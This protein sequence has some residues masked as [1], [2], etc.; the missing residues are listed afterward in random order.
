M[1]NFEGKE[2]CAGGEC[3]PFSLNPRSMLLSLP[4]CLHNT[5]YFY[6]IL[7]YDFITTVQK[8]MSINIKCC[9]CY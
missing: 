1:F 4:L 6:M 7:Y 9:Y 8:C 3:I 2:T 5:L